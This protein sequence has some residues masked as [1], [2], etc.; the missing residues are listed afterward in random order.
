MKQQLDETTIE[1]EQLRENQKSFVHK[2]KPI[3]VYPG[4]WTT[5]Y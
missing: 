4:F 3:F 5:N 2:K 1:N